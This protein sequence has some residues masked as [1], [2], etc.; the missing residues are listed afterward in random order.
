MI[1]Y[2]FEITETLQRIIDIK[3][4]N[5]IDA[6]KIASNMYKSGEI[7]LNS[8]DFIDKKINLLD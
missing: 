1:T 2:K 7:V 8:E 4:E 5:E 6:F 3:A